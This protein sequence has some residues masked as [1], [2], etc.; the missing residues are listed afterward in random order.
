M[1]KEVATSDTE[2]NINDDGE[3][4]E[5][6]AEGERGGREEGEE[7]EG[8]TTTSTSKQKKKKKSKTAGKLRKK[9][10]LS[11]SGKQEDAESAGPASS[12]EAAV[13]KSKQTKQ[14]ASILSDEEVAQLQKVIEKEQGPRAASK[15]DRATLE[16]LMKM[17]NLE[18]EALLKDQEAKQKQ[19][20]AIADHRFWKT[21][22]VTKPSK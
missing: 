13:G 19:H 18:K 12:T 4:E 7:G 8:H 16:K 5:E 15:A 20:K 3:A 10:G 14:T 9:L 1:E 17:M 2:L 11:S 22:P 6:V 21:Q